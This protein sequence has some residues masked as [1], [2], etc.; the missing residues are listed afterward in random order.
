[1]DGN[2]ND[3]LKSEV[4]R[5]KSELVALR[6]KNDDLLSEVAVSDF[7]KEDVVEINRQRNG[8]EDEKKTLESLLMETREEATSTRTRYEHE[9]ARLKAVLEQIEIENKELKAQVK[10]GGGGGAGG[11]SEITESGAA[12]LVDKETLSVITDA[13][14]N[15]ARRVISNFTGGTISFSKMQQQ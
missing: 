7:L 10:N 13:T 5:L 14:K 1:M 15:L 6:A 12:N 2:E 3:N 4:E 9:F 8:L 11:M